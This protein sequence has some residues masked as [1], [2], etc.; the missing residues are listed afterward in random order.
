MS[1]RL[2]N[3]FPVYLDNEGKP[4]EGGALHY[5]DAGT[6]TPKEVFADPDLSTSLGTSV[7]IGVDGRTVDDVWGDGSYYIRL[8][9]SDGTL[10]AEAD[11]VEI[12]GGTGT[13]IPSLVE[14]QFLTNAGGLLLWAPVLEVPDPTGQGGKQLGTDGT[15]VFWEPKPAAPELPPSDVTNGTGS[16]QVGT[17]FEQWGTATCS[18]S[19][20]DHAS[21]DITFPEPFDELYGVTLNVKASLVNGICL[22]ATGTTNET[23]NGFRAEFDIADRHFYNSHI[24][25]PIPF[26]WRAIGKKTA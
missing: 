26:F 6:A 24:T 14:G 5:F 13:A 22:V 4:A 3:V 20:A 19:G 17:H 18:A 23:V 2:L 15:S 9:A 16:L 12:P 10:I 7:A 25:S 21:H 8:L 1:F 11:D